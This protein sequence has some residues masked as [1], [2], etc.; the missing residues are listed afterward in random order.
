MKKTNI[1]PYVAPTCLLFWT[2]LL[3]MQ[4]FHI[5]SANDI[6]RFA[7][8]I[9]FVIH[10]FLLITV[11]KIYNNAHKN[12]TMM[13]L[14][15]A[16][17][18]LFINDL[19]FYAVT[20]FKNTLSISV[21]LVPFLLDLIPFSFWVISITVFFS[22]ILR[23]AIPDRK[24]Y[25]KM[26]L[27]L[28]VMDFIIISLFL[29]A[30]HYAFNILSAETISQAS[31][32]IVQLI[33]F[34]FAILCLIYS[35]SR[36]FSLILSGFI[37]LICGDFFLIYS[38]ISQTDK[39]LAYGELLWLLGLFI[40]FFGVLHLRKENNYDL[41]TWVRKST[42]IKSK[43]TIW[44]FSGSIISLLLLFIIAY[45]LSMINK[46]VFLSLPLF[47]MLY[48][49]IVIIFSVFMGRYFETP[50]KKIES[51]IRIL[52]L[53][54]D[55]Q[56][57]DSNFSTEEFIFL[58]KFIAEAFEFKEA[59]DHAQKE[60]GR[61]TAQVAHDIRSPLSALNT[62]LKHLPQIPESQRILMR[63]AA[64]R[65]NDIAN[66]LLQQYKNTDVDTKSSAKIQTWLLAPLIE[67]IVS[68]KRLQFEG[69]PIELTDSISS[70]SF[71]AFAKVDANE[72]KR[73]LSNLINNAAEA[74]PEKGG[75]IVVC[76]DANEQQVFLTI[77]DNG[78]GIPD[79]QLT[80]V[81]EP[82]VSFKAKGSGLG[83][84]HAKETI[85]LYHGKLRLQSIV[86]Q[87]T[88]IDI[89]LPRTSTPSWFT[90]EIMVSPQIQI[91][92]L[93][94][95]QS[96]HDAWDQRLLSVSQ[97]LQIHHFKSIQAFVDWYCVTPQPIQVLSD[98][99]LLGESK[100][101]LDVL[102]ELSASNAVLVT[103]YHESPDIIQRCEA[104]GLHLLPKNLLAHIPIILMKETTKADLILIDDSETLRQGWELSAELSGKRILSFASFIQFKAAIPSIDHA[105]PIYIDSELGTDKKGE[106]YAK[107]LFDI[108]FKEIYLV[109]GHPA[110]HFKEMPWI[111]A[112]VDKIP[113]FIK[114]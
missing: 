79:D 43:L 83:L 87:G 47:I 28:I 102:E 46:E 6:S 106:E 27:P 8:Q 30:I 112:I 101:G 48:S 85:E 92:I 41:S 25:L 17:I 104:L 82:G 93:D 72:M 90:S 12:K 45:L 42:R 5:R 51:N 1:L 111:K 114:E 7:A 2:I 40:I 18:F 57:I 14:V 22:T 24:F 60:L 33:V 54:D 91:G 29:S 56:K 13:W 81:L 62:C 19:S 103:S 50:F 84:S 4:V 86:N 98:Y 80:K 20:Y 63:N 9:E 23:K 70:A 61:M 31:T 77:Q 99:E 58:Q 100:T 38:F 109:T 74:L 49:I 32:F 39:L 108:G 110:S 59:K 113:H 96:V 88:T 26:L 15:L 36:G 67:S 37:V 69:Q 94:D 10:I 107:E 11:F 78:C 53:E 35:E 68:E 76:L 71:Y 89:T 95:D 75:K 55:P 73:L 52:M 21:P 44:F 65:I 97:D 64:N 105:T 34:D 16:L 3:F 66:N